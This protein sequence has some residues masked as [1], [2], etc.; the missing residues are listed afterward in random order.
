MTQPFPFCITA[1]KLAPN[2]KVESTE[3]PALSGWRTR[4]ASGLGCSNSSTATLRAGHSN[5]T[6]T[7][8]HRTE[9]M[10]R[11]PPGSGRARWRAAESPQSKKQP[12]S[13]PRAQ[14]SLGGHCRLPK[15]LLQR[16]LRRPHGLCTP[17]T[18]G[19]QGRPRT[20]K[21][22]AR[23][24]R[25][26]PGSLEDLSP[27]TLVVRMCSIP[28]RRPQAAGLRR[29]PSGEKRGGDSHPQELPQPASVSQPAA[30]DHCAGVV[31]ER[32]RLETLPQ[33]P[34]TEGSRTAGRAS[35][36]ESAHWPGRTRGRFYS[37]TSGGGLALPKRTR[38]TPVFS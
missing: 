38:W 6:K 25:V 13:C 24:C 14:S 10:V 19:Q 11:T 20:P 27:T 12:Q 16:R 4:K 15:Y 32:R 37:T 21:L 7:S 2:T 23:L 28:G 17:K 5:Q 26:D 36:I 30:G 22:P 35:S 31:C 8:S 33:T 9:L 1:V 29:A 34:A 3:V 18:A